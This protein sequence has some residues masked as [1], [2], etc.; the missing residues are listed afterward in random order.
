MHF[1]IHFSTDQTSSDV[2]H[3]EPNLTLQNADIFHFQQHFV[4]NQKNSSAKI[5]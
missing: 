2:D 5:V 3:S 4:K 1:H